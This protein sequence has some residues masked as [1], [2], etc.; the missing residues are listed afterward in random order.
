LG[1]GVA[2]EIEL[3][4]P[5]FDPSKFM[6]N[7]VDKTLPDKSGGQGTGQGT[8]K[9][10]GSVP[11]PDVAPKKA[12]P[13]KADAKPGKKG[14][15]PKGGKSGA[16][17]PKAASDQDV[18]KT[19]KSSMDALKSKAPYSK[20]ELDKALA[21]IK[22]KVN[23]VSFI[24][25]TQGEKWIVTASGSGKKKAAGNIELPM[26]KDEAISDEAKKGIAALDQVTDGYA[27]KGATQ[28]EMTAAVK[29][30]RRKFKFKSIELE[31]KDGFWYFNYEINPKGKKKGPTVDKKIDPSTLKEGDV[32]LGI[33]KDPKWVDPEKERWVPG[34]VVKIDT[35]NNTFQWKS[36]NLDI[37]RTAVFKLSDLDKKWKKGHISQLKIPEDI[38]LEL[39][40]K[41][42]WDSM[43]DARAILNYRHHQQQNNK[44]GTQWEHI[45]EKSSEGA[46]SSG[47]LALTASTINNK[48]GKLFEKP[49]ASHEAPE[50]LEGTN[51][52]ELRNYLEGKTLYIKNHWKQ[53]FYAE[54][55]ISLKWD[56]SERG[57]WR[58]LD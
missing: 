55:K 56:K 29:S 5:E 37:P 45:I 39:N 42:N 12:A 11:K 17:D 32:V 15:P 26:K 28:E 43:D 18:T 49:Y 50:G 14:T 57:V 33:Y 8:F 4:K 19:L 10:D 41:Q 44:P 51:G 23:G 30:V 24:A 2:P 31:K 13:K 21:A 16:P 25:K 47:N 46:H 54:L 3:K 20:T 6:T 53:H 58:K 22:G 9:E 40:K 38:L 27:S 52:K 36:S 34:T 35:Q 1:S 7:M 48:L